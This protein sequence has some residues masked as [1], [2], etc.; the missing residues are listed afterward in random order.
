MMSLGVAFRNSRVDLGVVV[1]RFHNVFFRAYR[2]L[3]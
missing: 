2:N 3:S 1:H